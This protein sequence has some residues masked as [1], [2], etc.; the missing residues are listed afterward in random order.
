MT[1]MAVWQGGQIYMC[2]VLCLVIM[3]VTKYESQKCPKI[4]HLLPFGVFFQA[5]THPR[6]LGGA[7]APADPLVRLGSGCTGEGDTL[8]LPFLPLCFRHL[9][10]VLSPSLSPNRNCWLCQWLWLRLC[11][12]V[13][14]VYLWRPVDLVCVT[15]LCCVFCT[16]QTVA[17]TCHSSYINVS[18]FNML[19][20]SH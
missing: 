12:S 10:L 15:S 19:Q 11:T 6:L 18:R 13:W 9:D 16:L 17:E 1:N 5:E 4:S 14:C 20:F 7:P 3:N 2:E 8:S